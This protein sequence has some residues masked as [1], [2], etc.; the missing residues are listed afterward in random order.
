MVFHFGSMA[1]SCWFR[2][3]YFRI[4]LETC[5]SVSGHIR[6]VA[7]P[8]E[9]SEQFR[10]QIVIVQSRSHLTSIRSQRYTIVRELNARS[11]YIEDNKSTSPRGSE[12][13]PE[14]SKLDS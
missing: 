9:I 13:V 10:S 6:R 14:Q 12:G 4:I 3:C 5:R 1:T 8:P 2:E 11:I 7:Y